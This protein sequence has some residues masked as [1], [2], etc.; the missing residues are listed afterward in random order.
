MLTSCDLPTVGHPVVPASD[1]VTEWLPIQ[2]EALQRIQKVFEHGQFVMGPEV[3]EFEQQLAQDVSVDHAITCSSG[4]VSLQIALMAL[5]LEP[6]DEVIL[7][8]FTFAAPLEVV[9][10]LGLKAMLADID[11]RT[12]TIDCNS[13]AALISPRTRAIIAVSLYGN[14]ANFGELNALADRLGVPV[15]EDAA[16]SYGAILGGKRSG[17]LSTIGCTSFFPTKPLG[18]AGDG[19]AL[20]TSDA[21]LAQRMRQIRDHGQLR[22]YHHVRLGTNGRLD[23]MSCA[24]LI[25]KLSIFGKLLAQRQDVARRYDE[26]LADLVARGLIQ[27][28]LI[29]STAQSA[30]AQYCLRVEARDFV[31][32]AMLGANV[33]VSVHY[34]EPLHRQPAFVGK[35]SFNALNHAEAA[36]RQVLCLPVYPTLQPSQQQR[37]AT[38]LAAAL[39]G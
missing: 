10:L 29:H 16:Q 22:K 23:S 24:A 37:V 32:Q 12:C 36:A 35:V 34:P 19:G 15:I 6:G 9:L 26:L 17:N 13:V 38:V 8:A 27:L 7:P 1:L 14:P 20:F 11:P 2:S 31:V 4:T 33:Q 28:Q 3:A 25:A 21:Q 30:F 5:D 18:G 39:H